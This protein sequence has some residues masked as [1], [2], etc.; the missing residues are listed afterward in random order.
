MMGTLAGVFIVVAAVFLSLRYYFY[1][2]LNKTRRFLRDNPKIR[3]IIEDGDTH[4]KE[5][6]DL[7]NFIKELKDQDD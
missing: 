2:K 7:D 4:H 3:K 5:M 6:M 1:K